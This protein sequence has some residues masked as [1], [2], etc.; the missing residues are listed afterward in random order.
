MRLLGNL[1]ALLLGGV[2]G[3]CV[4][5]VHARP[6]AMVLGLTATAATIWA[7]TQWG[8]RRVAWFAGGWLVPP[9]LAVAGRPEGDYVVAGNGPGSV[10][11]AAAFVVLVTGLTVGL[12]PGARRD[13][14]SGVPP[15]YNRAL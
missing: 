10:L 7:L 2:T 11:L 13:S 12:G 6:P 8:R 4:V 3:L 5:A 15:A 14:A 1:A 9:A